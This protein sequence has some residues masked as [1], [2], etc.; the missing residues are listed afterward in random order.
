MNILAFDTSSS[1][2]SVAI[3]SNDQIFSFHEPSPM[4]QADRIL[5]IIQDLLHKSSLSLEDLDAVAYGAGPGSFT[6]IRIAN[7]LAQG[8]GFGVDLPIIPISSLAAIAQAAF[9]EK[10]WTHLMVSVD[11]RMQQIYW[12]LY[13]VNTKEIVDLI[14]CEV[15]VK[16]EEIILPDREQVESYA[17]WYGVGNG[18]AQ[19]NESLVAQLSFSPK[20]ININQVPTAKA[21]L[22]L[23]IYKFNQGE[24]INAGEATPNY[25]R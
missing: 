17:D 10:C 3:Q 12:A 5:P 24:W 13:K 21:I 20:N 7:S 1:A 4:H 2:C 9:L 23:A 22:Q 15:L 14:G 19:Y 6:G 8:I 16:P 11:A 18:W 25:L